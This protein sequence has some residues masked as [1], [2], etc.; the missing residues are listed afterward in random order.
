[1]QAT[2]E[3]ASGAGAHGWHLLAG[4]GFLVV[5]LGSA[6]VADARQ[7]SGRGSS[8]SRLSMTA[9]AQQRALNLCTVAG[10]GAAAVHYAVMP[11]HLHESVLYGGFFL[12]TATLQLCWALAVNLRPTRRLLLTGAAANATVVG[13]WLITRTAGIPLGPAAGTTEQFGGLDILASVFEVGLVLAS[14]A[15]LS[16]QTLPARN[17]RLMPSHWQ[18]ILLGAAGAAALVTV[19]AATAPP[20]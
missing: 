3:G 16:Q 1:M 6:A 13:L 18:P 15:L 17:R 14:V 20:S 2:A 11:D 8:A 12:V 9:A 5:A 19:V 10:I 4:V 7:A